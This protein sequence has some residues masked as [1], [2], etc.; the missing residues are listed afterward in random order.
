VIEL[1]QHDANQE[2][3]GKLEQNCDSA[4]Y[5]GGDGLPLVPCSQQALHNQLIGS[6]AGQGKESPADQ[7]RPERVR[8]R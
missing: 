5:E 3:Q 1:E 4:R 6:M 7:S 8:L 2:E